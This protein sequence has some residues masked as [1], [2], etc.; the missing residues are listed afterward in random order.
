MGPFK[1]N[2]ETTVPLWLA[3][4]L[5]ASQ[6]CKIIP[7]FWFDVQIINEFIEKERRNT[8]DLTNLQNEEFFEISYIFMSRAHDDVA[9]IVEMRGLIEGLENIRKEK[10]RRIFDEGRGTVKLV[11]LTTFEANRLREPLS[12]LAMMVDRLK[13]GER[14]K[15][16]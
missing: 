1:A 8:T 11:N 3:L 15:E 5:K 10:I 7:P 16:K 12:R 4:Q 13:K 14:E 2:L 6:K 9:R